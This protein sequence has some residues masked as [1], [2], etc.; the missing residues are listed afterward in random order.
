MFESFFTQEFA[1]NFVNGTWNISP[2]IAVN[3]LFVPCNVLTFFITIIILLMSV[4]WVK[5]KRSRCPLPVRWS[6]GSGEQLAPSCVTPASAAATSGCYLC[7]DAGGHSTARCLEQGLGQSAGTS[8]YDAICTRYTLHST[9]LCLRTDLSSCVLLE[10]V[11][12]HWNYRKLY[13]SL[14][15]IA[16]IIMT[17]LQ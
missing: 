3:F 1:I 7:L 5:C 15:A 8:Q 16:V 2:N 11:R 13:Y 17:D 9:K 6:H 4:H 12:V 14:V 10:M